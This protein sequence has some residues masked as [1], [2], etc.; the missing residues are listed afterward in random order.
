MLHAE[1]S[2][3]LLDDEKQIRQEVFMSEQGFEIEFDDIDN[4]STHMMLYSDDDAVGCCRFFPGEASGEYIIGRI[5]VRKAYR[6]QSMGKR[7]VEMAIQHIKDKGASKISLS[8]QVQAKGFYEALGFRA[9]GDV[10]LD[11]HCPHVHM[12][13]VL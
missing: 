11:E 5:A 2:N 12:E 1:F 13:K 10:Y 4:N 7:I 6:G 8:A 9:K 3:Q